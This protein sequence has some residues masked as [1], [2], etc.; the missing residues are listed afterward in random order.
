M[1]ELRNSVPQTISI[2]S[3]SSTLGTADPNTAIT[4]DCN[5]QIETADQSN[6]RA[7]AKKPN[8]F[9]SVT[10]CDS[11]ND[12]SFL[13]A[14]NLKDI[15]LLRCLVLKVP[16]ASGYGKITKAWDEAAK[17][18]SEQKGC[19]GINVFDEPVSS[20]VMKERVKVL[21][22]WIK[23][24]HV[25]SQYK[26][27][28]DDENPPSEVMQLLDEVSELHTEHEENK[29]ETGK[30]KAAGRKRAREQALVIRE[31]SLVGKTYE[32][33]KEDDDNVSKRSKSS[34]GSTFD[35]TGMVELATAQLQATPK[36][37]EYM[38]RKLA[39][40]EE[41]LQ[42]E[43]ARFDL[44]AEERRQGIQ[45]RKIRLTED[46]RRNEQNFEMIR[47]QMNM[48][49]EMMEMMMKYNDK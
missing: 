17:L 10:K 2:C 26:S 38:E 49:K 24:D 35:L 5:T 9:V 40:S 44:E 39:M 16:W 13:K 48:Q 8:F 22:K 20:K 37:A 43:T 14:S 33:L 30:E 11:N 6:K 25:A 23:D 28:I 21:L 19:D 46:Q 45:E 27:G 29:E 42:L 32:G 1:S 41:K 7:N 15:H 47:T 3:T 12:L 31:A 36:K 18:L 4:A 34:K